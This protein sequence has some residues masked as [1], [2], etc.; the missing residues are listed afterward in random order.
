[1]PMFAPPLATPVPGIAVGPWEAFKIYHDA[2]NVMVV[3]NIELIR[4]IDELPDRRLAVVWIG[5]DQT[6]FAFHFNLQFSDD[7]GET[8]S[9]LSS[10]NVSTT[11]PPLGRNG[12]RFGGIVAWNDKIMT[13]VRGLV[14]TGGDPPARKIYRAVWDGSWGAPSLWYSRSGWTVLRPRPARSRDRSVAGIVFEEQEQVEPFATET[15]Y[16][17]FTASGDPGTKELIHATGGFDQTAL[18]FTEDNFPKFVG[19]SGTTVFRKVK[20]GAGWP[21]SFE[22]FTV[23]DPPTDPDILAVLPP[24]AP[25]VLL[26]WGGGAFTAGGDVHGLKKVNGN[27]NAQFTYRKRIDDE[28]SEETTDFHT[29][30][31]PMSGNG[32]EVY[33]GEHFHG[34]WTTDGRMIYGMVWMTETG[35]VF[36]FTLWLVRKVV[37]NA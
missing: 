3:D 5:E 16:I 24:S 29:I 10:L 11:T 25:S 23:D 27:T 8:W 12:N 21:A 22:T 37:E 18:L 30:D 7:E 26:S 1:M 36:P 19:I 2:G 32:S 13:F 33:G 34:I 35:F 28:W 15:Q 4:G 17:P 20:T 6:G 31:T 9:G 14:A